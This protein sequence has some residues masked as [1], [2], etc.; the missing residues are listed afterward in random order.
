MTQ[1]TLKDDHP[2]E[3][4]SRGSAALRTLGFTRPLL[5]L[6][7]AALL[8]RIICLFA[9]DLI[10]DEAYYWLFAHHLRL[11]YFDHPP[12]IAW[13]VRLGLEIFGHNEFAV[14]FT[15]ALM[16]LAATPLM[17]L[18]GRIWFGQAAGL[19]AALLLHI[20]PVYFGIGLIATP[21]APMVL[22]WLLCLVGVS[23]ALKRNRPS[24]WY[25]GGLGLG[26]AMIS[27]YTGVFLGLGAL[28]A[29]LLHKPWRHHL[30]SPHPYLAALLALAI[31]SPV[32]LW[33]IQN[34]WA[35]IR[36][37]FLDRFDETP[38]R[39]KNPLY[40]ILFQLAT[41]TPV[42]LA[43]GAWLIHRKLR[44][45]VWR[46]A[47]LRTRWLI[48]ACFSLPLLTVIALR[49]FTDPVLFHWSA[50]VYLAVLPAACR[51]AL[52]QARAWQRN[53]SPVARAFSPC[54]RPSHSPAAPTHQ[55]K[56]PWHGRPARD[57]DTPRG[58]TLVPHSRRHNPAHLPIAIRRTALVSLLFILAAGLYLLAGQPAGRLVPAFADW[59][60]LA[61]AVEP[62]AHR[63][64]QQTGE[65]PLFIAR[66]RY[67]LASAV[68]FYR[69]P[70]VP[71]APTPHNT[72]GDWLFTHQP[73]GFMFWMD[74]DHFP[75]RTC[76]YLSTRDETRALSPRFARIE[77]IDRIETPNGRT[78]LL[79]R[80]DQ[81][82]LDE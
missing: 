2:T 57:H 12:L 42:V 17:Y 31:F 19:A 28:L 73:S 8:L 81:L 10:P 75:G 76:L 21:D 7:A 58:E 69:Q 80:G 29:V 1:L 5:F 66:G 13:V 46:G 41:A 68:A 54:E 27:K 34:D 52:A 59:P 15:G 37:Q 62:H 65:E 61:A 44:P 39:W 16:M 35:S 32:I 77:I 53:T 36:F 78:Y 11:S 9:L 30:R 38:A 50:P 3:S 51:L 18:F 60:H 74:P 45:A 48:A 22:F 55:Q 79:H 24:A 20:L 26:L 25:L 82:I 72:T 63:I 71:D 6:L 23:I 67:A 43:A 40:F 56:N 4:R 70:L 64:R 14:R 49:S 47:R 33:N